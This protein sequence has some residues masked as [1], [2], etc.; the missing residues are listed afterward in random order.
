MPDAVL[1]FANTGWDQNYRRYC[2]ERNLEAHPARMQPNLVG[3]FVNFL[4]DKN[5]IV[6]DPF[7]GSNT[8]GYVAETLGRKWLSVEANRDYVEGSEGRF[9]DPKTLDK[10]M[11]S[12]R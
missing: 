9:L 3:F 12:G 7:A 4:T 8:T 2:K 11:T 6:F 5:D 1:G 10:N